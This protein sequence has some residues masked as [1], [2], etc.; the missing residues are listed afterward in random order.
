[1]KLIHKIISTFRYTKSIKQ[2]HTCTNCKFNMGFNCVI[3]SF[4]AQQDQDVKCIQGE[5]WATK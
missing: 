2:N 1:M 3:G 5:N 4:Y